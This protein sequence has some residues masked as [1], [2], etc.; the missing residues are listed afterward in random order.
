MKNWKKEK[1]CHFN[2][3]FPPSHTYNSLVFNN[4][5]SLFLEFP[6]IPK[7]DGGIFYIIIIRLNLDIQ[8]QNIIPPLFLPISDI[9]TKT[10]YE[11][12]RPDLQ[13]GRLNRPL[14]WF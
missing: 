13:T 3:T 10:D 7:K 9:E 12:K 5:Y 14:K 8:I 1:I 11:N 4:F 2:V 6:P